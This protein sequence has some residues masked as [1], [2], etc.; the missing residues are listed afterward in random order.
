MLRFRIASDADYD[1]V[2][3]EIS[4]DRD[5]LC[6]LSQEDGDDQVM[7]ELPIKRPAKGKESMKKV[8]LADFLET[9]ERAREHFVNPK[10]K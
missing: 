5:F 8:P 4:D 6:L 1:H 2:V 7:I 10:P 9:T 3:C